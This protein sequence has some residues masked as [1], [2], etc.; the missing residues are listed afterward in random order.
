MT[1]SIKY[2]KNIQEALLPAIT[3][4]QKDFPESF[5]L[6]MPKILLAEILLVA[7]RDGK[8]LFAAADCTGH[9]FLAIHEYHRQLF[10][11]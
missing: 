6:Y 1:D 4:L 11:K 2:A 3:G 10:I 9:V 7:N 5:V 8:T